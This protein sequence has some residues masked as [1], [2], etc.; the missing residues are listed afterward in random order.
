MF[1]E[2]KNLF[3]SPET[4][5]PREEIKK[6]HPETMTDLSKNLLYSIG[7]SHLMAESAEEEKA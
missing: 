5:D 2:L 4:I 7:S 6:K 1:N 3:K